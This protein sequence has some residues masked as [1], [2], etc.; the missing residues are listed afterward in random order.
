[1]AQAAK[2]GKSLIPKSAQIPMLIAGIPLLL[3]VIWSTATQMGWI[4]KPPHAK[5]PETVRAAREPAPTSGGPAGGAPGNAT[6][7]PTPGGPAVP[8]VPAGPIGPAAIADLDSIR[9]P[10][11][12]PMVAIDAQPAGPAPKPLPTGTTGGTAPRPPPPPS[13]PLPAPIAPPT[14]SF[15]SPTTGP[16]PPAAP[17]SMAAAVAPAA[18][19]HRVPGAFTIQYPLART[20]AGSTR[21]PA[22][23]EL[24]GTISGSRGTMAVVHRPGSSA[25]RGTYVREG[26]ALAG[27]S[28]RIR[29]IQPGKVELS[30]RGPRELTIRAPRPPEPAGPT[31]PIVPET[32]GATKAE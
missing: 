7:A 21:K 14:G 27:S 29:S 6:P 28:Q 25:A 26:D 5:P 17:P 19:V 3:Y 30:G 4:G 31:Q 1:M 9:A 20:G 18:P 12:D 32:G 16:A 8:G 10:G 2:K 22:P 15:P 24:V 11:G 23:V 13:E